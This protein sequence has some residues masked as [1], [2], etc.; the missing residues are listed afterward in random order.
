MQITIKDETNDKG[1]SYSISTTNMTDWPFWIA[2]E[3][4]EGMSITE[5]NLFDALDTWYKENF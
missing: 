4:G 3:D 1:K 5:K 2:C